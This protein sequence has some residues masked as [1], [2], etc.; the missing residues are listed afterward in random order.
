VPEIV[1]AP[2]VPGATSSLPIGSSSA[3]PKNGP[4]VWDGV[5]EGID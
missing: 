4:T 3:K 1:I 5:L 2:G